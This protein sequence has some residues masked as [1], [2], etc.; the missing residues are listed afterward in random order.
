MAQTTTPTGPRNPVQFLTALVRGDGRTDPT[1]HRNVQGGASR[2]AVLGAG[3]GLITNVSLI[4]GVA[5]AS[6]AAAPVRLAGVAGLLA[7]AFS[8]AAGELVSVR[9]QDELVQREIDVEREEL[10]TEPEAERRELAAMY[11]SRGVPAAD[12]ETV[13][14]ILS[15]NEKLALDTHARLELG[16]DP[17]AEGSAWQASVASFGS[18]ALGAFLPLIPWLFFGGV[19]AVVISVVIGA[20][21]SLLLG[22]AIG[23]LTARGMV[24]TAF[25]Q[26][27]AAAVAAGITFAV[28]RLLGVSTS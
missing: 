28:G 26:F 20:V 10:A 18:F 7:G 17:D 9:A 2:A 21:A 13:A 14:D 3:D 5:G 16:I 25:R 12:A 27:V 24:R 8:M 11:R 19:E 23:A 6:T 22:A 15:R 1:R 4:L